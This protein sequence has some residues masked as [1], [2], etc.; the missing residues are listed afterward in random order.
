MKVICRSHAGVLRLSCRECGPQPLRDTLLSQ[1]YH[2]DSDSNRCDSGAL[3]VYR[4]PGKALADIAGIPMIV[5]VW[6]QTRKAQLLQ[7]VLIATDDERIASAVRDAGG[8]AK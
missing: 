2:D 1:D 6:R 8:E 5:R 4:L 7:R 3:W